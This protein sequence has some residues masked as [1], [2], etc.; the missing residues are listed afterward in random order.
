MGLN[1]RVGALK[2]DIAQTTCPK[3]VPC[4]NNLFP[5]PLYF[6]YIFLQSVLV[7]LL[8]D[9]VETT[10]VGLG[11]GGNNTNTNIFSFSLALSNKP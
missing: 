7:P 6:G 3:E 5:E 10:T 8:V 1:S 11:G 4:T 2:F 9:G